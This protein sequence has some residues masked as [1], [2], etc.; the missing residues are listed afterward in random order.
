M[1]TNNDSHEGFT[2][3]DQVQ[4]D[5]ENGADYINVVD[6]N[7]PASDGLVPPP[8]EG[9]EDN[10]PPVSDNPEN[11]EQKE[12]T[13]S[14][15]GNRVLKILAV[16][17]KEYRKEY[18]DKQ[19]LVHDTIKQERMSVLALFREGQVL[20]V[21]DSHIVVVMGAKPQ[22]KLLEKVSNRSIVQGVLEEIFGR[23][24]ELAVIDTKEWEQVVEKYLLLE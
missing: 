24:L 1:E 15:K 11:Q 7:I 10:I 23:P 14:D 21:S 8:L 4:K 19:Q 2:F 22:V 16:A 12:I 20:A 13:L 9:E 3:L 18:Y 5:M 6:E 17:K